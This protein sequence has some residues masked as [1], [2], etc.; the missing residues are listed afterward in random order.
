MNDLHSPPISVAEVQRLILGELSLRARVGY[1]A[2]L[3]VALAMTTVIASLWLT[4]PHLPV[5]TQIA[6]A[7]MAG[8]GSSWAAYAA[9]VLTRR[10]VLL[11]GHRIIAA[12]MAVAF[13]A[14]FVAG[15][16]ALGIWSSMG[17]P[18]YAAAALGAMMLI[19]AVAMLL[20]SRRRFDALMERRGAL[21]REL[22]Q[23]A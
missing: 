12:R 2:L 13:T 17:R 23:Q 6:F 14:V 18:A 9:W 21:E 7:V 1:V 19:V 8:I 20:S 16:L 22:S 3:L 5:R 15:S 10:R 4:E 11:A